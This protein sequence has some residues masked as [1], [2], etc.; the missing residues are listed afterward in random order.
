[1]VVAASWCG[2]E[3]GQLVRSYRIIEVKQVVF[4]KKSR[5]LCPGTL[6]F[7]YAVLCVDDLKNPTTKIKVCGCDAANWEELNTFARD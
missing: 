3:T 1:M 7:L 4:L 6:Q 5:H 2:E